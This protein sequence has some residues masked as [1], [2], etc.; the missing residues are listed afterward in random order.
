MLI[1]NKVVEELRA[2]YGKA[3]YLFSFQSAVKTASKV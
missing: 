1:F 2:K 3:L